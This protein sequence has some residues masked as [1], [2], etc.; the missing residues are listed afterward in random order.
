MDRLNFSRPDAEINKICTLIEGEPNAVH[1]EIQAGTVIDSVITIKKTVILIKSGSTSL[2]RKNDGKFLFDF[3]TPFP[4]GIQQSQSQTD[5]YYIQCNSDSDI[6]ILSTEE[7][8]SSVDNS[9]IWKAMYI[10]T[11]YLI[12][13]INEVQKLAYFKVNSYDVVKECLVNIWTLSESERMKTSIFSYILSRH[14]ISRS[15]I[16]KILK[17]LN[18]GKYIKTYRGVLM[19]LNR[20]PKKF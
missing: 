13:V 4:F 2:Y 12:D 20:L 16:A 6:F 15:S 7:F 10:L 9:S 14:N 1:L 5:S 19:E 11:C 17:C 3:K 8:I 18:D